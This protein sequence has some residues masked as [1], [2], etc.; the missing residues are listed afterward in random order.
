MKNNSFVLG[1]AAAGLAACL[2]VGCGEQPASVEAPASAPAHSAAV[3]QQEP[4][5]SVVP[6]PFLADYTDMYFEDTDQEPGS[7]FLKVQKTSEEEA[8]VE[9]SL[10]P[11]D[12]WQA[13]EAPEYGVTDL[14]YLD[15]EQVQD[16][17]EVGL[18]DEDTALVTAKDKQ[19][20][21]VTGCWSVATQG[22]A[23]REFAQRMIE[24]TK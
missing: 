22:E 11:K 17:L 13:I 15:G 9:Q 20:G 7:V 21:Q 6:Q 12:A 1:I 14:F 10:L 24:R 18:L 16:A 19:S 5:E 3:V 2:L 8:V 23:L 4:S